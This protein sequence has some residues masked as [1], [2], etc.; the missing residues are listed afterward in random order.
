MSLQV[1]SDL[2]KAASLEEAFERG[3]LD[4]EFFWEVFL[5]RKPHPGQLD[6]ITNA[7]ATINALACSNRYGKT[8]LL[9]GVHYHACVYKVG[10]EP[11]FLDEDGNFLYD[12]YRK[13]R[14]N[15]VHTAGEWE[16]AYEVWDDALRLH[17]ES[18]YLQAFV[19]ATPRSLPPHIDFANGARWRFRTLGPNG[20]GV[21]GKSFY[22]LSIDEAGWIT[23]LEEMMQNVLR[24]RVA[25]VR[26]RIFIVGTFKPGIS[27]DFYK[28]CVRASAYTGTGL[29]LDHRTNDDQAASGDLDAAI[30]QY[31]REFGLDLDGEIARLK[32][33]EAAR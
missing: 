16:Q 15:T 26:G 31:A 25:D 11:R 23:N 6:F 33:K 18:P 24:V 22:V 5:N 4:Q 20:S 32:K 3:R 27:K 1:V 19:K 9:A 14:Y 30:R 2:R 21:D 10:G 13:L 7:Q 8:T 17:K 12:E 29:T 28:V